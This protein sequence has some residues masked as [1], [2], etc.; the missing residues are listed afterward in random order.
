M[1]NSEPPHSELIKLLEYFKSEK[2]KEA[3]VLALSITEKFPNHPFGWKV[4]G[5]ILRRVGRVSE[6]LIFNQKAIKLDPK[7]SN[8]HNNLGNNLNDLSRLTE[9]EECFRLAF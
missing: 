4:L 9:A 5:S 1:N 7:D 6:A 2:Y 3:E 8:A